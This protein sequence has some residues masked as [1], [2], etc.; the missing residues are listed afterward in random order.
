M[1]SQLAGARAYFTSFDPRI[2]ERAPS[3]ELLQR[4]VDRRLKV[5][6]LAKSHLI[7]A[8]S[9]L[10]TPF[11][12]DLLRG[13]PRLLNEGHIVPALRNDKAG[14]E[15]LFTT[16]RL[17]RKDHMIQF[18]NEQ[19]HTVVGWD[20]VDNSSWFKQRMVDELR[21]G[22]SALRRCLEKEC[23][24]AQLE[25]LRT[26]IAS[27]ELLSRRR[28]E[29]ATLG[30]SETA[31]RIVLVF[32]ELLYH[33]S[34]AR[35]VG[36]ESA[37]PQEDYIDYDLADLSQR[38]CRL[39][40]E[41]IFLK[42]FIEQALETLNRCMF[43]VQLLDTLTYDDVL[44]LRKPLIQTDFCSKYQRFL[45]L[46]LACV[47]KPEQRLLYHLEE[48]NQIHTALAALIGDTIHGE[49]A[50]FMKKRSIADVKELCNS[51]GSIALSAA[52]LVPG[53]GTIA[54]SFSI[55]KDSPALITNLT[56]TYRSATAL[57]HYR[58]Y[59][60]KKHESLCKEIATRELD[61]DGNL[62]E[63]ADLFL[64]LIRRKLEL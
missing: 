33:L 5:L 55:L 10:A 45:D 60:T 1:P 43:P 57:K 61:R 9:H 29:I 6:L 14:I 41:Q 34:G 44:T 4:E 62:L 23:T 19:V 26:D 47:T 59:Q 13:Q 20:V 64:E 30:L 42:L 46:A 17:S 54:G 12:Y 28:V 56:Q 50:R 52:G 2:V 36:A 3:R 51:A 24:T 27:H 18:Y 11:V 21:D 25:T 8:A 22:Y 38:R 16:K 35:V 31:R 53:L 48:L 49:L 58:A 32:R 39:T 15:E 40:D 63:V 37:L 7:C